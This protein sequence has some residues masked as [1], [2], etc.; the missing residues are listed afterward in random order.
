MSVSPHPTSRRR[1][2]DECAAA[3]APTAASAYDDYYDYDYYCY[4]HRYDPYCAALG[5][6][7]ALPRMFRNTVVALA[8]TALLRAISIRSV[9]RDGWGERSF[10]G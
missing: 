1:K 10:S 6:E 9:E 3:L 4:Y 2:H 5:K 8:A 7:I